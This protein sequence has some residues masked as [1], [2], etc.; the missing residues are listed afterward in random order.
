MSK[1]LRQKEKFLYSNDGSQSPAKK[2]KGK[3]PDIER[4]LA[5]W[6]K[7]EQ[8]KGEPL[9]D[10]KIREQAQRFAVTVGNSESRSKLT[11]SAWLEKFKQKNNLLGARQKKGHGNFNE[12]DGI[13]VVDS[14]TTSLSETPNSYS[15]VSSDSGELVSP[16]TSPN[17]GP[18]AGRTSWSRPP[19]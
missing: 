6:A 19:R 12:P 15:P 2:A 8:I 9:N 5:N 16:P 1:V 11:N 14:S 4:A 10:S 13:H 18:S 3:F 17:P 7:N